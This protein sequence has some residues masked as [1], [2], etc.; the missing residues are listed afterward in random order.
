MTASY[1]YSR[2]LCGFLQAPELFTMSPALA[3]LK[4]TASPGIEHSQ[5]N[6]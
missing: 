5:V 6:F 3:I 4:A 1:C 2:V